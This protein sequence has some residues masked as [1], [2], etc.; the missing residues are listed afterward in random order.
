MARQEAGPTATESDEAP[1]K[2]PEQRAEFTSE[3][4]AKATIPGNDS[5]ATQTSE[6][7]QRDPNPLSSPGDRGSTVEAG[8]TPVQAEVPASGT[9]AQNKEGH[10][11][12]GKEGATKAQTEVLVP[13]QGDASVFAERLSA[14]SATASGM[15]ATTVKNPAQDVSEQILGSMQASLARGDR[16]LLVR[17]DPPE[18]GNVVVRFQERGDQVSGVLE[19]SRD[20]TRLEVEQALPEELRSLQD[21]GLQVRRPEVTD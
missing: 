2:T 8:S 18:L 17:L 3:Q 16:Q 15:D 21:A 6:P 7:V 20:E 19:V 11:S 1:V 5:P 4:G 14:R 13:S 12:D 10:F 9:E